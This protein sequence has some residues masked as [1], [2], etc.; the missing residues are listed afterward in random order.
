[1]TTVYILDFP[2]GSAGKESACNAGDGLDPWVRKIP[3]R[4]VWK[5]IPKFLS[6]KFH[7]QRSLAG[8]SPL[9][10]RG[11]H[12]WATEQAQHTL[13]STYTTYLRTLH[14]LHT[15]HIHTTSHMPHTHP[16]HTHYTSNTKHTEAHPDS[17][18]R[19]CPFSGALG[20]SGTLAIPSLCAFRES[21]EC[22]QQ[23]ATHTWGCAKVFPRQTLK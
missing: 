19:P 21:P 10:C 6:G 3:C 4:N 18:T 23:R 7:G 5:T 2:C 12:D 14:Q 8:Y 17:K 9:G 11:R 13:Y 16:T 15:P 1:M 20:F 22:W